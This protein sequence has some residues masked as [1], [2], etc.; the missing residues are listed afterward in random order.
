MTIGFITT[1]RADFGIY[2]PL[3][4]LI[5]EHPTFNYLIFTGGMHTSSK[6]GNS[7]QL[8]E[9]NYQLDIAEKL[10]SLEDDDSPSGIVQSMANTTAAYGKIWKKYKSELDLLFVLGDRFEMFAAVASTIPFNIPIAHLH[11]GETTL[12]AIDNKFRHAIT[13][14]SDYHFTSHQSNADRVAQ[15]VNS[16]EQVYNVGAMGIDAA[17]KVALYSSKEFQEK[18]DFD[19]S[20]PFFLTT[21][22]PETVDLR[23]DVFVNELIEAFKII[24]I[25]VLNTL[26]NA[27]TQGNLIRQAFLKFEKEY[28]HLIKNHE[29]LGQR[30][31]LSAMSNCMMMVG[32]TSSGIIEAGAFKKQVVNIGE[33]QSGRLDNSNIIHVPNDRNAIVQGFYDAQKLDLTNFENPYG[34]GNSAEKIMKILQNQASDASKASDI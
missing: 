11:G 23:N 5:E 19:I 18:F 4:R 24:K 33:R 27:D 31:Y 1:S 25:P 34:T 12:G 6:F 15:I 20:K 3:I 29:N 7:Y 28:P 2:L 17:K 30:G 9:K 10:I 22:H 8:I 26:P 14:M 13:A 21:Y 32:N 16:K